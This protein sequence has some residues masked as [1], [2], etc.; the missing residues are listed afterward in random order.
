MTAFRTNFVKYQNSVAQINEAV[1]QDP[2]EFVAAC[3]KAYHDSLRQIA[4]CLVKEEPSCR[5]VMLAGPS[6]SGKTTTAHLLAQ[7]LREKGTG[8]V[9]ISLDDFY[10]GEY[11]AP[12]LPDGTRD[13]ESVQALNVPEILHCLG[14]LIE[15]GRCEMP[16]FD[17]SIHLPYPYKRQVV[18]EDR[19]IAIVEGIHALNPILIKDLPSARI[20]RI[21]ISVKQGVRDD[22][23]ELI[24]PN[25]MRLVRR[26]VR[27][28]NFRGTPAVK[29]LS[30]WPNVMSGEYKYIKPYRPTADFTINSFHAHELCVLKNQAV[31]LLHT[32][33]EKDPGWETAQVLL[34]TLNRFEPVDESLIPKNSILREF[35][36]GG[37][38]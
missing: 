32:V 30:M 4:D 28:R 26:I 27:D 7:A 37:I 38:C 34:N 33:P 11:E 20:K 2:Q 3:E 19:E 10:R 24:G 25:Q 17:F 8:A 22:N 35:I 18:L 5:L 15:H 31:S 9:I 6:A 23:G 12:L 29:T 14:E 21:Y 1:R 16:V 13:Y 36:G